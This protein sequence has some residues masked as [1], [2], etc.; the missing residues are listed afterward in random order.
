MRGSIHRIPRDSRVS[1]RETLKPVRPIHMKMVSSAKLLA[2][3]LLL[4]ACGD[5]SESAVSVDVPKVAPV[6]ELEVVAT[7]PHDPGAF[8]QGLIIHEG[9]LYESTGQ[10]GR[11]SLRRMEIGSAVPLQ[12]VDIPAPYFAEGL[13]AIGDSLFQITWQERTGF[14]YDAETLGQIGTFSYTGEGWGLTSDGTSLIMSDGSS[15]LRYLDPVTFEVTGQLPVMDGQNRVNALNELEWV[16]GEIWAN[17]WPVDDIARIDP[18]SGQVTGW[19]DVS[20]LS[21]NVRFTNSEAV[22]NGVAFDEESGRLFITGK[23]WP[24]IYEVRVP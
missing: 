17:I 8:S 21:P 18:A 10:R 9:Y 11:S 24:V 22:P 23:L 5:G 3:I 6:G 14:I 1:A 19:V 12:Q 4:S 7:H 16:N 20:D 2:A 13:A 15:T